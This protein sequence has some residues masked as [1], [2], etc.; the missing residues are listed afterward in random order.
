MNPT[1]DPLCRSCA[2]VDAWLA[3]GNLRTR[4]ASR[5]TAE[6]DLTGGIWGAA[7]SRD[8]DQRSGE[9]PDVTPHVGPPPSRL[10]SPVEAG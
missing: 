3:D 10:V 9:A 1:H 6:P 2:T 7:V 5:R 4:P 8:G